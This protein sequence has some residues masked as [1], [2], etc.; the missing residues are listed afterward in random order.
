MVFLFSFLFYCL[1]PFLLFK[2][3]FFLFGVYLHFLYFFLFCALFI[4]TCD[5]KLFPLVVWKYLYFEII[6]LFF[7]LIFDF[8]KWKYSDN[9]RSLTTFFFLI[10]IFQRG[11]S[12]SYSLIFNR[13]G[14]NTFS[15]H[16][17]QI[18]LRLVFRSRLRPHS[19]F[20]LII[21]KKIVWT[22]NYTVW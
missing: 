4:F 13:F 11:P 22:L 18:I 15:M 20:C 14:L 7:L 17:F 2:S 3:K 1:L 5:C 12:G 8:S 9:L 21:L 16:S 10:I 19:T 6:I